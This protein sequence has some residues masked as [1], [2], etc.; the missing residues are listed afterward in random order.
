MS[1]KV[2]PIHGAYQPLVADWSRE[3]RRYSRHAV[4]KGPPARL[5]WASRV[6]YKY[7]TCRLT[8]LGRGGA[9]LAA[10]VDLQ[11]GDVGWLQIQDPEI[12]RWWPVA[13]LR[14][15][16]P[17]GFNDE[18]EVSIRFL[19]ECEAEYIEAFR[20]RFGTPAPGDDG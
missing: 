20:R 8:E 1:S 6:G 18:S 19:V 15:E 2:Q 7:R 5:G 14:V 12:G 9:R 3:R 17:R 10:C 16:E 11:P 13:V 4:R